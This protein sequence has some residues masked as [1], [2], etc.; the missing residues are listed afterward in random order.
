MAT[1]RITLL[2]LH[3]LAGPW[4]G[5]GEKQGRGALLLLTS[6]AA[7]WAAACTQ[8][9]LGVSNGSF[10][11]SHVKAAGDWGVAEVKTAD[12]LGQGISSA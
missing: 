6:V 5:D 8:L 10:S 12:L 1:Q 4:A 2:N 11:A 3:H 7:G 9:E